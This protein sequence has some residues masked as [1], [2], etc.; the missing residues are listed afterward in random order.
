MSALVKPIFPLANS[1]LMV[2]VARNLDRIGKGIRGAPRDALI[3]DI[4]PSHLRG[5]SFGLR[6][7]L[8]TLGAVLGPLLA[9]GLMVVF[10]NNIRTVFWFAA[11]PAVLAVITL[12]LG[13]QEPEFP[14]EQKE[15]TTG[16]K[17]ADLRRMGVTYWLV[18]AIGGVLTLARF[19]EAFLILRAKDLGLAVAL[20]PVV[21]IVMSGV[22][23][24]SAYPAGALSD[25]LDRRWLLAAGLAVLIIADVTLASATGVALTLVGVGLW[26]LH[27]G[28]TQGVLS[29]LVADAA[30]S[31]SRGT[32]FGL[33]GL[34]TG[35]LVLAASLIAGVLWD[36]IGP[37]ATFYAG[38]GYAA[39]ALVGLGALR[40]YRK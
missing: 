12:A 35:V 27:M 9:I 4:T 16:L 18:V 29:T 13:V 17:L 40:I 30:P 24:L 33:Y 19:S 23:S 8:D 3:A 22:Y 1:V 38:A 36:K 7:S 32:A 15:S 25:R 11:I 6:Q 20:A 5:A 28:L 26:G 2:S 39:L 14:K 10:R 37:E 34:V 21:L 31:E